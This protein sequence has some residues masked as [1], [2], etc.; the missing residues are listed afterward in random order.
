MDIR[1]TPKGIALGFVVEA[2]F[3]EKPPT[4][5]QMARFHKFWEQMEQYVIPLVIERMKEAEA[6]EAPTSEMD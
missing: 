2:G 1:L 6:C 3:T 5:D 4:D